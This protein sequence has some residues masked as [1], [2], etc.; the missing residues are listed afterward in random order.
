MRMEG[1]GI[2]I[3][4]CGQQQAGRERK[5]H[6]QHIPSAKHVKVVRVHGKN[7]QVLD[8]K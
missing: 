4:T 8:N 2:L 1:Q 5:L 3:D 7:T 6:D